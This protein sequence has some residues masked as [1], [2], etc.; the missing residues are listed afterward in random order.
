MNKAKPLWLEFINISFLSE[1]IKESYKELIELK[2]N[3]K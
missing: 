2:I 1:E 3:K